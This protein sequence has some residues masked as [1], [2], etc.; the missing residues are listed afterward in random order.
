MAT[1]RKKNGGKSQGAKNTKAKKPGNVPQDLQ[2]LLVIKLQALADVEAQLIKA[3]PKM[4]QKAKAEELKSA[5]EKHAVQTEGHAERLERALELM[6]ADSRKL[7]VEAIRGL[8]ADAE[9]TLKTVKDAAVR[10]AAM[11]AAAQY[12]EHYEMAGYGSAAEWAGLLGRQEVAELLGQTLEEE[13]QTD[14]ELNDLARARVN[15]EAMSEA[16]SGLRRE[17]E[18]RHAAGGESNEGSGEEM[19]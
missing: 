8:V 13:K 17:G 12:V 18:A 19:P 6:G 10:D 7:K 3:L 11:I 2:G 14:A 15:E 16:E 5:F 1:S 9:W 4:A